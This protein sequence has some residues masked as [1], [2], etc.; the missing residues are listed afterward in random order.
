[1]HDTRPSAIWGWHMAL[2][3]GGVVATGGLRSSSSLLALLLT[4][5]S[6]FYSIIIYTD[7]EPKHK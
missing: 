4:S 3:Q 1:M 6:V 7:N 2:W 5:L